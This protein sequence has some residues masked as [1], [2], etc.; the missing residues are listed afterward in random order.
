[1]QAVI[2][3]AGNST[4]TYPLTVN[5]PKPLLKI[6]DTTIIERNLSALKKTGK[7]T[8][9]IIVVGFQKERIISFLGKSFEGIPVTYVEQK[10]ID[11]S[12]GA[13][14]AAKSLL[15][16]R[17]IVCCGDDLYSEK[18]LLNMTE[19]DLCVMGK[20]VDDVRDWGIFTLKAGQVTG[21]E[22]K[23]NVSASKIA[24]VGAYVLD[25]SIFSYA[26]KK[27]SRGELELTDYIRHLIDSGKRVSCVMSEDFWLPVGYPW[28]YLEANVFFV[29][30][31]QG[32]SIKGRIEEGVTIKG[33]VY[34]G[35][36]TI[37][38]SGSYIDG[39]AYI[40]KDC[41]IGPHAYIRPDSIIMDGVTFRGEVFDAVLMDGVTAKHACYLA[42]S[43]IGPRANIGAGTITADFRHDGR[44]NIT[45]VKGKK[46]DTGRR[47]L[48]AFLG[49]DVHTGIGTLIYPGRKIWPGGST[50]PGEIVT[51]DKE[52][53]KDKEGK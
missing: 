5:T 21:F 4:R 17:F 46:V 22:E 49:E 28:K 19:K 9:F 31:L 47:K 45:L 38:K 20:E 6:L 42:H 15:K 18:D 11:G 16:G 39:P 32:Q 34:I 29:R 24:N 35:E 51:K 12:G 14:N 8:S 44:S 52:V 27:T 37:V 25:A 23:P 13:L 30:R 33:D 41:V 48:G 1:M 26:L 7:V 3:A 50:L 2:L 40:G 43:V 10:R 53:M 36:G